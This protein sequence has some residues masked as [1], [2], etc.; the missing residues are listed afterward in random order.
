MRAYGVI[1]ILQYASQKGNKC[2]IEKCIDIMNMIFNK[3]LKNTS[4]DII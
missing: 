2:E 3:L 4:L 1:T